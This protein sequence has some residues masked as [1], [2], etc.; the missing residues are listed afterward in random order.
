MLQAMSLRSR[1]CARVRATMCAVV[2]TAA[3]GLAPR[4][5]RA[6]ERVE[7]AN[8][9]EQTQRA[10]QKSTLLA[11]LEDAE[12]C[13]RPTCP[14][15]LSTECSRWTTEIRSKIP[16]LVI[17]V[18]GSD[19]CSHDGAKIEVS[20][21]SRKEDDSD[22]I[23]V[24]PGVHHVKVTDPV[25][26]RWKIQTMDFAP[27]ERRDIDV[28]FGAPDATCG[29]PPKPETPRR[30]ARTSLVLGAIGGGLV[31]T[32]VGLGIIGAVK[33]SDLDSCKPGCSQD[34]ID[35]VRPFFVSGDVVSAIGL[36]TIGAGV[37]AWYVLERND[38]RRTSASAPTSW[39]WTF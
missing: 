30:A 9:Y 6:D 13:A 27:G 38:V 31:V 22:T 33:R 10:Q 26:D 35:A 29:P 19:G 24:D 39:L 20:G 14:A 11:A 32:G 4:A 1:S 34:R 37:V 16:N 8:A 3:L 25:S 7:C 2:A 28:D 5:A 17:R 23:L 21:A 15:L 18:R 12:R 36:L